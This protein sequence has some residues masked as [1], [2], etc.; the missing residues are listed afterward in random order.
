MRFLLSESIAKPIYEPNWYFS[1]VVQSTAA[2]VAI[3]G[4]FLISRL[5][6]MSSERNS[7]AN[8][9][10]EINTK[11]AI[12]QNELARTT[13]IVIGRTLDWFREDALAEIVEDPDL[14]LETLVESHR[15]SGDDPEKTMKIAQELSERVKHFQVEVSDRSLPPKFPPTTHEGL[16]NAGVQMRGELEE[17][18]AL[19]VSIKLNESRNASFGWPVLTMNYRAIAR[20]NSSARKHQDEDLLKQAQQISDLRY[21]DGELGIR[22]AQIDRLPSPKQLLHGFLI[23]AYFGAVGILIPLHQMTT[24]PLIALAGNRNLTYLGF[25]SGFIWLLAYLGF[26]IRGLFEPLVAKPSKERE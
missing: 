11:R 24:N 17:E 7:L 2:L 3:L 13:R 26:S 6:S 21:L 23:L 10:A 1:T 18:I 14:D 22:V 15:F 8:S 4:G 19:A 25:M 20:T 12:A 16:L 9:Y 5:V